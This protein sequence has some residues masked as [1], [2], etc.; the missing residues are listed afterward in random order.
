MNRRVVAHMLVAA[1]ALLVASSAPLAARQESD[2]A[3]LPEGISGE[4][5]AE[6]E[7]PADALPEGETAAMLARFTWQPD[8]TSEVPAG[9]FEKG[10]LVDVLVEGSYAM[11]SG[12]PLLVARAGADGPPEEIAEVAE[13]VLDTGDAVLYLENDA[14]WVFRNADP[15]HPGMAYEALIIT[16]DPPALPVES[17]VDPEHVD[18]DPALHLD[19]LARTVPP[20]WSDGAPGPLTL[21][22]WR[23]ALVP[24]ATLSAPADG[25]VQLVAAESGEVLDF[26]VSPDGSARNDGQ[27]AVAIVG[28]TVTS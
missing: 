18:E 20:A 1:T 19:V 17:V 16:T 28:L 14:H 24:G 12:G 13:A 4:V 23:G 2:A 22:I 6:M 5:L 7:I 27:D 10:V 11:R 9:T 26:T 15:A 21:T 8:S 3:V 25:V